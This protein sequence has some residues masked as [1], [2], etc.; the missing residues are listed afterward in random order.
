MY[1]QLSHAGKLRDRFNRVVSTPT[2]RLSLSPFRSQI[3]TLPLSSIDIRKK[4]DRD[5]D[6][7]PLC[8]KEMQWIETYMFVSS[9]SSISSGTDSALTCPQEQPRR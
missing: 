5:G 2:A 6:D 1:P 3:L 8:Y 9:F 4:C 7:G